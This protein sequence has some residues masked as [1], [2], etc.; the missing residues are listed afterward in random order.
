M[1]LVLSPS[2]DEQTRDQIE[3]HI[4]DVQCRR[5]SAAIVYHQGANAKLNFES[6][7]L[8]SRIA[9]QYE[10]LKKELDVLEKA[11]RKVQDRLANMQHLSNEL[12]LVVDMIELHPVP[13][14][15]ED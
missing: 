6:D 3:L 14:E 1:P 11:E 15:T 7:K 9:K 2:F 5:L 12:G 8:R 13:S 4:A 10:L